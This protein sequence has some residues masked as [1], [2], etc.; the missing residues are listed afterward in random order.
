MLIVLLFDLKGKIYYMTYE[1]VMG[2]PHPMV[3]KHR[4][5]RAGPAIAV[6]IAEKRCSNSGNA[7]LSLV[8]EA[9]LF[10]SD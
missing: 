7:V 3:R 4:L 6:A 10:I 2:K 8:L 9:T 1:K 5:L